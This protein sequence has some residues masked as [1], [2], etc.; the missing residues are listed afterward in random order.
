MPGRGIAMG[1]APHPGRR[2]ACIF[3]PCGKQGRL[4]M[5]SAPPRACKW[6]S[7][8]G[9]VSMCDGPAR[10]RGARMGEASRAGWGLTRICPEQLG[11]HLS[12]MVAIASWVAL[13][14]GIGVIAAAISPVAFPAGRAGAALAGAA[15]AFLGGGLFT[16]LADRALSR[17]DALGLAAAATAAAVLLAAVRSAQFAEPRPQ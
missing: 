11:R 6:G 10:R 15:G 8:G 16:L 12:R 4:R 3:D 5:L 13:G 17:V 14:G 2:R 1:K 7:R 9:D